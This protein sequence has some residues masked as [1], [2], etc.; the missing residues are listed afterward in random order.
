[1]VM[2]MYPDLPIWEHI[3]RAE[4]DIITGACRAVL[5]D[6]WCF[7]PR[8]RGR[9]G[10]ARGFDNSNIPN[11]RLVAQVMCDRS[12]HAPT[13]DQF[14]FRTMHD[15]GLRVTEEQITY[16]WEATCKQKAVKLLVDSL[17]IREHR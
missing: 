9:T 15:M 1:M 3:P 7:H 2:L 10:A 17:A 14:T 16:S 5:D 13:M 11:L 6:L 4:Y 12:I 8:Y